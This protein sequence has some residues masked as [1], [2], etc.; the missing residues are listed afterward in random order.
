MARPQTVTMQYM[1][2][3]S[4]RNVALPSVWL[5][6]KHDVAVCKPA[7]FFCISTAVTAGGTGRRSAV[8]VGGDTGV[9]CGPRC[10][11]RSAHQCT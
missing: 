4:H 5:S 10:L 6:Q 9:G 1:L 11:L 7:P 8:G 2:L 3:F